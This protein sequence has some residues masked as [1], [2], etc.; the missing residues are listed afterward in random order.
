[1]PKCTADE[2][3]FGRQGRRRIEANFQGGALSSD[4][5]LM[6]LRQVDRKIGLSDAVAAALHDPRD[7]DLIKHELRDLVAQRLYGLCCGYEDLNDH[8]ALRQDPLM[9]TAVGTGE[10]L[11]SSPTLCRMEG[12]ASRADVAALN[13]VLVE[14]FIAGHSMPPS[15]LVLDVDASDIPLH[16]DQEQREFHAYYDHYCY[17]PL[18]VYC[19]KAMLACVLRRSRIDGA[20]HAAAVIKLLVTRLRQAWPEVRIIVRGD[21]GFCRQRLIRWCERHAVGY[22]IGVARNARLHRIVADWEREMAEQFS[23]AQT[24]QRQIREFRYAADSWDRER[25]LVTR[26]EFGALGANPRFIVTNLTQSAEA[27]YD[28]LYCQRGEAENRIKETQLDLFGTRASSRKFLANWLRVLF[29]ALAYTLMQRLRELALAGTD[30]ARASAATIRVKLLKI[31]A[32]VIRNT[33]RIRI[34]FASHHPLRDLFLTAARAL[35]SP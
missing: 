6:L 4:G 7:P 34:L 3:G 17:L 26:L 15:E 35:A 27:L 14:Q 25:R 31:G 19:G 24:K 21:S 23:A 2:L 12:R 20:K 13:R 10:A 5:G 32:A 22:V 11:A 8:A 18:Y 1:M 33:R 28:G 16:G 9:Q 29:S 30:L